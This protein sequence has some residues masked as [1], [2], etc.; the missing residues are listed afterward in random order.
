MAKNFDEWNNVKKNTEKKLKTILLRLDLNVP[1]DRKTDTILESE[2]V[3]A[4]IPEIKKLSLKNKLVIL[5]HIGKGKK[6]DT[7]K[8]VEDYL[9][10]KLSENANKNITILENTR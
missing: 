4:V 6:T 2:R 9:R 1:I 3:D 7:I 5:S 8:P 10:S